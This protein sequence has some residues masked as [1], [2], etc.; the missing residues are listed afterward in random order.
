M[1]TVQRERGNFLIDL[2]VVS[3]PPPPALYEPLDQL[4]KDALT[5]VFMRFPIF[6]ENYACVNSQKGNE[7]SINED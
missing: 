3:A 2:L 5:H 7:D 6:S 4:Q 1:S